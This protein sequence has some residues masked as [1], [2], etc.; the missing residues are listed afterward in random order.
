MTH[1]MVR[2]VD[3]FKQMKK[4]NNSII[5]NVFSRNFHLLETPGAKIMA[6]SDK[7]E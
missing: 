4:K 1:N 3:E 2:N 6:P 7:K 5:V